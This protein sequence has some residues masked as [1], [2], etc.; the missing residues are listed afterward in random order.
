MAASRCNASSSDSGLPAA[1]VVDVPA[2]VFDSQPGVLVFGPV[3]DVLKTTVGVLE[4]SKVVEIT[5]VGVLEASKVPV[6]TTFGEAFNGVFEIT[7]GVLDT[8]ANAVT[9]TAFLPMLVT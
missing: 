7:L 4:A 8:P 1:G 2:D 6:E 9:A 3:V 5:V